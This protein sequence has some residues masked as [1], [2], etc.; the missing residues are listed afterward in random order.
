MYADGHRIVMFK[1]ISM[2]ISGLDRQQIEAFWEERKQTQIKRA[3]KPDFSVPSPHPGFTYDQL[4]EFTSGDPAKAFG[5][6]YADFSKD[7]FIARLPRP[8]LLLISRIPHIEPEPWVLKPDGWIQA[9][10]DVSPDAW[11]FKTNRIPVM[12]FGI[13]LEI[14]LQPCGWL[15][16]YMG[17]ALRSKNDL[18]FRNLGGTGIILKEV[19]QKQ[20]TL[21]T[22]ARLTHVSEA[23]EMIIEHFDFRVLLDDEIVFEGDTN[24]GFFTHQ[25]L[26]S[27]AGIRGIEKDIYD[28]ASDEIKRGV[29]HVFDVIPPRFPD[30]TNRLLHSGQNRMNMPSKALRMIDNIDL[31]VSD[32]GPHGL[33]YIRG[34]KEVDPKEWFFNS[35]FYQD[36]VCPGSLGVESFLQL[37]KFV[38]MDKFNNLRTTHTFNMILDS[39]FKWTYRGQIL[40]TNKKIEVEAYIKEV[41]NM[42]DPTLIADGFLKVDGLYIYK[43]EN[44]GIQLIPFE[45]LEL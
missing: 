43:M 9:E 32:G 22:Q 8:P 26:A 35:H 19:F 5:E 30:D 25:S 16:A 1:D 44:F 6:K 39:S 3:D 17:S 34:V 15:A 31:Y 37:L 38:A 28:P 21:K 40:Q 27:Q 45:E 2:K 36:P 24:F 33:G 11:Y 20:W 29:S 12:P 14:T 4:L 23:A 42:P 18:K 13:L 7:R 10:F 41:H